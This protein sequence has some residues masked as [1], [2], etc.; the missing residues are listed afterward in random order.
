MKLGKLL[1]ILGQ[2]RCGSSMVA[3]ICAEHG[4]W[5]G[6]TKRADNRNINGFYENN[7][8]NKASRVRFGYLID[9][10]RQANPR[11]FPWRKFVH[12]TI[13][14]QGC[15]EDEKWLIKDFAL[16]YSIWTNFDPVVI[17][18]RRDVESTFASRQRLG[19]K[20]HE[21]GIK[22]ASS[23]M[24][25]L[26]NKR[27]V[28]RVDSQQIIDGD[29]QQLEVPLKKMGIHLNEKIVKDF[30]QPDYWRCGK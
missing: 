9:S 11:A 27:H 20:L 30:I 29:Y 13:E 28:H 14:E 17:T 18:V 26:E 16:Y 7:I 23:F 10:G 2:S 5:T 15:V 21:K 8:I 6:P 4:L 22:A 24:D 25:V 3:G 19:W 1:L 12:D